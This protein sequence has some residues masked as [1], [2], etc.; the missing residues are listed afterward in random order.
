MGYIEEFFASLR[1]KLSKEHKKAL[2]EMRRH[3]MGKA[4]G[5]SS[6][7]P[8]LSCSFEATSAVGTKVARLEVSRRREFWGDRTLLKSCTWYLAPPTRREEP[9]T[10]RKPPPLRRT[11]GSSCA[12]K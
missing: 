3:M 5:S 2:S 12:R 10:S 1:P 9:S 8:S 7:E 4:D 11:Q 6:A